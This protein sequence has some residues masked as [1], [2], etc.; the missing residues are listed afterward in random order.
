M[1]AKNRDL[2]IEKDLRGPYIRDLK[3]KIDLNLIYKEGR[4]KG[5]YRPYYILAI[6][7]DYLFEDK[8]VEWQS[9]LKR[10]MNG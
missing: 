3:R 2:I 6:L 9:C 4:I 8:G 1:E 7:L 5:M 10:R